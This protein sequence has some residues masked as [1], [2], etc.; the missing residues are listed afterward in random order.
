MSSHSPT[1]RDVLHRACFTQSITP[2]D[3]IRSKASTQGQQRRLPREKLSSK[4][5]SLSPDPQRPWLHSK[6]ALTRQQLESES[7]PGPQGT[8]CLQICWDTQP[9]KLYMALGAA[10]CLLPGRGTQ[11]APRQGTGKPDTGKDT[12]GAKGRLI[13][14]EIREKH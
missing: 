4:T 1:L 5:E 10:R 7:F 9:S 11:A 8:I 3:L 14:G 13:H 2:P 6:P 12:W